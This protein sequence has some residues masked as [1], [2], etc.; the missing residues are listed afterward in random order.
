MKKS[1][2]KEKLTLHTEALRH[3]REITARDLQHVQ[4][5]TGGTHTGYWWCTSTVTAGTT[6]AG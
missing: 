5:G 3:L 2:T 6:G 1:H 4:G